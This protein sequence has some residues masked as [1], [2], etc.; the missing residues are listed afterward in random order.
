MNNIYGYCPL[1]AA[2]GVTR[3]NILAGI[4]TCEKG[5]IYFSSDAVNQPADNMSRLEGA[6]DILREAMVD[7][8]EGGLYQTSRIALKYC[9]Y[10]AILTEIE[11][12][13]PDFSMK[14]LSDACDNGAETCLE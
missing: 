10:D 6:M 12:P 13:E 14:Q 4:D 8:T 3:E 5:H 2:P 7:K 11:K 9:M 1:C